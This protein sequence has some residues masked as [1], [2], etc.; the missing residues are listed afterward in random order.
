MTMI[1]ST[2]DIPS[3]VPLPDPDSLP[4]WEATKDG[5][6]AIARCTDCQRWQQPPMEVCRFCA[7]T[8]S[9]DPVTG[10]GTV[11]SFIL[12]RQMTVPGH[13]VPY[14]VGLIELDESPE[15]RLTGI[16]RGPIEDVKIGMRVSAAMVD[17]PGTDYQSPEFVPQID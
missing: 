8:L 16:V 12:V 7:G 11:Y 3:P 10:D 14:V 1:P 9:F 13:E 15:V 6:L 2:S 17:V 5:V 4:Y